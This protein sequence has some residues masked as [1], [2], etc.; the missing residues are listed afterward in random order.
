MSHCLRAA[1]DAGT[2]PSM[3]GEG[4][5]VEIDETFIGRKEGA[6]VRRGFAHMRPVP[7]LVQRGPEG[8]T[9]R[10]FHVSGI[11][12]AVLLPIIRANVH[13]ATFLMT[14][15][16]GQYAHIGKHFAGHAFTTYSSG[17][18]VRGEVHT[19]TV[20]GFYSVFKRRMKGIYQHCGERI[21]CAGFWSIK[22]ELAFV[23]ITSTSR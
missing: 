21:Y 6:E 18:Y 3:D 23:E 10:S 9:V 1:M 4:E 5:V 15:E 12:A 14:D 7:S 2:L 20:E 8:A 11:G 22:R 19:N 17:E 13:S 16:A